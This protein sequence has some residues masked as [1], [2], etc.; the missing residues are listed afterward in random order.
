MSAALAPNPVLAIALRIGSASAFAVMAALIKLGYEHGANLVETVFYRFA[1]SLPPVLLAVWWSGQHGVWR[2]EH[3][4]AHVTRAAIG[5]GTM[6]MAFTS[7]RFLPLAE[8]T[9][10]SFVAPLFAV[11]LSVLF[12]GEQVGR[13]RWGAVALG[14]AGVAVV[15]QPGGSNL[16]PVGLAIAL[17]AAL[18]VATVT[19]AIRQ[20][21]RTEGTYTTVLW[22]TGLSM[23]VVGAVMPVYAQAHDMLGWAILVGVGFFGGLGQLGMT[24]SLRLAPVPVIAPFDYTQLLWAVLF[25]W[26]LWQMQ[27]APA[28]WLGAA[29]IVASGL[30]T[31]Y[32]E[33]K[34]A[35]VQRH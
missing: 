1:F 3:P 5:L 30:Y 24:A 26:L 2:T 25:G 16:P 19:I 20:L 7:L 23:L 9:T 21:G 12:L 15:M 33:Q 11:I 6:M 4:F 10:I 18:G 8:A 13:H 28:T 31:I 27:P 29:M 17:A 35:R 32:R 14:F 22:F 34:R